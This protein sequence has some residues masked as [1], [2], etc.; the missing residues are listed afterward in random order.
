MRLKLCAVGPR[1]GCSARNTASGT[2]SSGRLS[3]SLA[4]RVDVP[5]PPGFGFTVLVRRV[6]WAEAGVDHDDVESAEQ[7]RGL[8]AC[9]RDGGAVADVGG[10]R[11]GAPAGSPDLRARG[12]DLRDGPRDTRDGRTLARI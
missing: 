1:S 10:D 4:P 9:P 8:V 5:A 3:H 2:T 12:L 7:P 11:A 6:S